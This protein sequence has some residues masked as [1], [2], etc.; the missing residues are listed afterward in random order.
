MHPSRTSRFESRPAGEAT[1]QL[2]HHAADLVTHAWS[3]TV[4]VCRSGRGCAGRG[5][6]AVGAMT[7]T[8][9]VMTRGG[10]MMRWVCSLLSRAR[11]SVSTRQGVGRVLSR[12]VRAVAGVVAG[13]ETG[14]KARLS[15]GGGCACMRHAGELTEDMLMFFF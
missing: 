15:P 4:V 6:G 1:P 3:A 11:S 7:A 8:G 5:G 12:R 9:V 10:G 13:S 14:H 2:H